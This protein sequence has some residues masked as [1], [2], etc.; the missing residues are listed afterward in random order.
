MDEEEIG[1]EKEATEIVVVDEETMTLINTETGE[2]VGVKDTPPEDAPAVETATWIGERRDW[3]KGRLAGLQAEKQSRID[4]INRIFDTQINRHT[5]AMKYL[6]YKY[7]SMLF[8]LA[9]KLIGESKKRSTAVGLL[10][11]KL[12]K[13]KP[14][15][16]IVDNDKAVQYMKGLVAAWTEKKDRV[17]LKLDKLEPDSDE[18]VALQLRLGDIEKQIAQF[19]DC[20]NTKES[21]YK[22][23]IPENLKV[24]FTEENVN[25]T[26]IKF[27]PGGEDRLDIE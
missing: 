11:L 5:N 14:S 6:E 21:I 1:T 18:S 26:G 23:K 22:S 13:T 16:D 7:G 12:R 10:L 15:V 8:D 3:H 19:E 4:T 25:D 20:I 24:E 27:E 2:V 17:A 9:K